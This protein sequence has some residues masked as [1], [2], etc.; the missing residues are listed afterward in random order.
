L[1]NEKKYIIFA[2]T[3]SNK[4]MF[5]LTEIKTIEDVRVFLDHVCNNLDL[6]FCPDT[7][8]EDY[9][10]LETREST[11]TPAEAEQYNKLL[12][13]AFEVCNA[14]EIDIHD[15]C[16]E[17]DKWYQHL[18]SIGYKDNPEILHIKK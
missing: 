17:I 3:K 6:S 1:H 11:F 9:I 5:N 14:N 8:F 2:S 10:N 13:E 18:L 7:P 15:L 4:T 16:C 12:N